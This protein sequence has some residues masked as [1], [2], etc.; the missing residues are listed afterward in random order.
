MENN[1]P[2]NREWVKT[3]AIIF[4]SVLLVLTFFSNTI[5][6]RLLPE[7]STTAV[8]DG[9]IT[10]KVRASGKVE[11]AGSNEVKASG[12]RTVAAVKVKAGQEIK[13]G[14]VLFVMG[15]AASE[16]LE[17][18][19][20]ARDS[21]YYNYRRAQVSYPVDTTAAGYYTLLSAAQALER[22]Y[23][24]YDNACIALSQAG[25]NDSDVQIAQNKI[26]NAQL[27]LQIAT[28]NAEVN[29][30]LAR[31][32]FEAAQ[33]VLDA[34]LPVYDPSDPASQEQYDLLL[35]A[36]NAAQNV[37]LDKLITSQEE[38]D[39]INALTDA[40]NTYD[41]LMRRYTN[42]YEAYEK[43]ENA[44][45]TAQNSYNSALASYNSS[46]ATYNQSA[47]NTAVT[48]E[49]AEHAYNRKEE[50]LHSLSGEGEDANVYA[51][52][53]G[54][55]QTINVSAGNKVTKGDIMCVI[56]VPDMGYTM[57]ASVTTDQAK[58]LKV[59]DVAQTANYYWGKTVDA[60]I[61]SIKTDPKDPQGKR[62]ITFDVSG[63]ITTG[64]ELTLSVGAKSASY[65]I[66]V[67]K[68]AVM[69]D[70]NGS[71]VLIIESKSSPLGN[72]YFARRASVEVLAEDDSYKAV[73]GDLGNGDF[74]IM[75]SS[76]K[77]NS[78]DQVRLADAS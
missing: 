51:A 7:V 46:V 73:S 59:G 56:E 8:A 52:V 67:P 23:E 75:N 69:S 37:Y 25:V 35:A 62:L 40:E 1:K 6:N 33:A 74:V 13:T 43:A 18:A 16:E 50:K 55:V 41:I 29:R 3:A 20:D 5:N 11:A 63:D 44:M 65:D 76:T 39:A 42:A 31:G 26:D 58:R 45:L 71:F 70:N 34:F 9:T 19:E 77:I 36:V 27:Q 61:S 49:E 30:D 17:A 2:K 10:A 72:R 22:A 15:S 53:N 64:Q 14:D 68:S 24:A 54:I 21:A 38:A 4:L 12:T 48:V 28:R 57:T 78:G 32:E 60:V 47:A 66:V